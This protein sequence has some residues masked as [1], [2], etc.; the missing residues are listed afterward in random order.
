MSAD[1]LLTMQH[2]LQRDRGNAQHIQR[3]P[4]RKTDVQGC[5]WIAQLS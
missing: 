4:G 2:V 1:I 5:E 3:V